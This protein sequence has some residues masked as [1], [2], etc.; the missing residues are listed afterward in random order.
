MLSPSF[1]HP[2]NW[3]KLDSLVE[4]SRQSS[5]MS[6]INNS[7]RNLLHF[8][9][10]PKTDEE[11]LSVVKLPSR[12]F[13]TSEMKKLYA[14]KESEI[15]TYLKQQDWLSFTIDIW[16]SHFIERA[17]WEPEQITLALKDIFGLEHTD[18]ASNNISMA[19]HLEKYQSKG[20]IFNLR[21]RK[22]GSHQNKEPTDCKTRWN[23]TK[24]M[25]GCFLVV[26]QAYDHAINQD[27]SIREVCVLTSED[28]KYL[29][30]LDSL[31]TIFEA[32]TNW[33]C[34]Q[35][36]TT[37]NRTIVL[38]NSIF[39]H[40][41]NFVDENQGHSHLTTLVK[42]T[43]KGAKKLAKYYNKTDDS[44]VFACS[45]MCDVMLKFSYWRLED[46][47]DDLCQRQQLVCG[48]YYKAFLYNFYLKHQ[49]NQTVN[50]DIEASLPLDTGDSPTSSPLPTSPLPQE[51][52][53]IT[54]SIEDLVNRNHELEAYVFSNDEEEFPF[55]GLVA[56]KSSDLNGYDEGNEVIGTVYDGIKEA[57][58]N[59]ENI[60]DSAAFLF[61]DRSSNDYTTD[62]IK[63]KTGFT[64]SR[65][66]L[67][68][69]KQKH[70]LYPTISAFAAK[71]LGVCSTSVASERLFSRD[72]RTI[73][74]ERA[75]LKPDTGEAF[76]FISSWMREYPDK[77]I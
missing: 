68:Y 61:S 14:E 36:Y 65:R 69:W 26:K 44:P 66:P 75:R 29:E 32:V 63:L 18:N 48:E 21:Q 60:Q 62:N 20:K 38:I 51:S 46:W 54:Q 50:S 7:F 2:L 43:E 42:A 17:T 34:S 37:I 23:S 19:K 9:I 5:Q 39:E 56:S 28:V 13:I 16:K 25:I 1:P 11:S 24:D 12:N 41:K 3:P 15:I 30:I 33:L 47:G 58:Y 67:N 4:K 72:K 35:K 45:T 6:N 64:Y 31:L 57:G 8:S 74:N 73:N 40:S 70:Y 71:I 59:G 10:L 77:F 55:E 27:D 22:T 53:L 76:V 49:Q 52:S